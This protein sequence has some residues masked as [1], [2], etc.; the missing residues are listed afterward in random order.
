MN[1]IPSFLFSFFFILR[2]IF[3][4][5]QKFELYL[6]T[7]QITSNS[8]WNRWIKCDVSALLSFSTMNINNEHLPCNKPKFRGYSPEHKFQTTQNFNRKYYTDIHNIWSKNEHLWL[9][10]SKIDNNTW[11][12]PHQHK[13]CKNK[14]NERHRQHVGTIL[15]IS[16]G[17]E[18]GKNNFI[19]LFV[20]NWLKLNKLINT[21]GLIVF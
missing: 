13:F 11:L 10:G 2:R 19:C 21:F 7:N 3:Q 5:I 18:G 9:N 4:T 16:W 15:A 12:V 6:K 20:R 1:P 8:C 17:W 14:Q